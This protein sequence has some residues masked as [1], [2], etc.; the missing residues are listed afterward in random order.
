MNAARAAGARNAA[1]TADKQRG[2]APSQLVHGERWSSSACIAETNE[3]QISMIERAHVRHEL[4]VRR[5]SS[6]Q[7][8]MCAHR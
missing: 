7:G 1:Q 5:S 2:G 4:T 3:C 8:R 6:A